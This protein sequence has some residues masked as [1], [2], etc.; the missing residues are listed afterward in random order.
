[1]L[2]EKG[3]KRELSIEKG[4]KDQFSKEF[5]PVFYIRCVSNEGK[6]IEIG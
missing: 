2:V 5:S 4:P 6:W 3:P 1:M